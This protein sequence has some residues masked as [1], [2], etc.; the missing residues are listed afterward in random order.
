MDNLTPFPGG[1][2]PKKPLLP[3]MTIDERKLWAASHNLPD[4]ILL[5]YE[6]EMRTIQATALQTVATIRQWNA[7]GRALANTHMPMEFFD[8][9]KPR[10]D[11]LQAYDAG[12]TLA[13]G[14]VC[15][16]ERLLVLLDAARAELESINEEAKTLKMVL[17][18]GHFDVDDVESL[19]DA[20]HRWLAAA[21]EGDK[22]DDEPIRGAIAKL[23]QEAGV[24]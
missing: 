3:K 7:I 19:E 10:L 15:T 8:Q 24:S 11:R 12:L 1:K 17:P 6:D 18:I 14:D 21:A 13:N 20:V 2:P 5:I 9:I 22:P 16:P 23:R 4:G